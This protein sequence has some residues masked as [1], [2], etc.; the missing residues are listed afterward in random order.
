MHLGRD[1]Q[2]DQ[3]WRRP[4]LILCNVILMSCVMSF[5]MT[6]FR[7]GFSADFLNAWLQSWAIAFLIALPAAALAPKIIEPL[8]SKITFK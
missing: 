6:V 7:N 4:I 3:K 1:M 8:L 2:L 5:G